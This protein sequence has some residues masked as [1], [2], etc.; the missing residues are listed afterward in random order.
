MNIH[1]EIAKAEQALDG[2]TRIARIL[3]EHFGATLD[4]R[5]VVDDVQR[6]QTSLSVL[7]GTVAPQ[8]AEPAQAL[9]VIPDHEYDPSFWLD[10]DHE[11]VGGLVRLD[12]PA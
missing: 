12:T 9:Q 1:T 10:A 2:L 3:P 5:R 6:L 8:R 7:S 11:G 4:V